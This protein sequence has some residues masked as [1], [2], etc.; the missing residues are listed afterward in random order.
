MSTENKI[1]SG[2]DSIQETSFE[3]LINKEL[4]LNTA[5]RTQSK[6]SLYEASKALA[7][8]LWGKTVYKIGDERTLNTLSGEKTVQQIEQEEE[9]RTK[10]LIEA[11]TLEDIKPGVKFSKF[12]QEAFATIQHE[13]EEVKKANAREKSLLKWSD[14]INHREEID[15]KVKQVGFQKLSKDSKT[16]AARNL[17]REVKSLLPEEL[18]DE[19][20]IHEKDQVLK[21]LVELTRHTEK[22]IQKKKAQID[23]PDWLFLEEKVIEADEKVLTP[24]QTPAEFSTP[25]ATQIKTSTPIPTDTRIPIPT[26]TPTLTP[27]LPPISDS[28]LLLIET[29]AFIPL[30]TETPVMEDIDEEDSVNDEISSNN[31]EKQEE[32]AESAVTGSDEAYHE[33]NDWFDKKWSKPDGRY[34][35]REEASQPQQDKDQ[36]IEAKAVAVDKANLKP[37]TNGHSSSEKRLLQAIQLSKFKIPK[38]IVIYGGAFLA[39]AGGMFYMNGGRDEARAATT[40][41]QNGIVLDI[42]P[43]PTTTTDPQSSRDYATNLIRSMDVYNDITR[44]D[45]YSTDPD[46]LALDEEVT[47]DDLGIDGLIIDERVPRVENAPVYLSTSYIR[48]TGDPECTEAS[49]NAFKETNPYHVNI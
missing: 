19:S 24:E 34:F 1:S 41:P 16:Q 9:K 11:D 17:V 5:K 35:S 8:E 29:P 30:Q 31:E 2:K 7:E 42:S 12:A 6:I 4:Q 46:V 47:I 10:S 20:K 25:A 26:E 14:Y 22:Q 39:L 44:Q 27:K 49:Y 45:V 40:N 15:E 23:L 13:V 48:R 38:S 32:P 33:M 28:N 18:L 3:E 37:S 43:T 36:V 21:G